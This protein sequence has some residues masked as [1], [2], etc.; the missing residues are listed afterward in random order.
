MTRNTAFP[1]PFFVG[2]DEIERLLERTAKTAPDGYPPYNVE[3]QPPSGEDNAEKLRITLAVAGFSAEELELTLEDNELVIEGRQTDDS[4][5]EF[6][7]RGIAARQF[8]RIFVLADGMNVVSASLDN[9]L[10]AI[11]LERPEPQRVVRKIEIQ[12]S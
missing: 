4:T 11:D 3:K 1:S 12:Q 6:L 9:G 2:F 7:H 8:R 5:R 10:L